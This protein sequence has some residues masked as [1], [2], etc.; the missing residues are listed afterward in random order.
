MQ[1]TVVLSSVKYISMTRKSNLSELN[2][3]I[4]TFE[5]RVFGFIVT[6]A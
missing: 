2:T 6:V 5:G 4:V 3:I 1:C